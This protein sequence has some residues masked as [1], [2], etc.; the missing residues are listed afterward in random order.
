M[1]GGVTVFSVA[2]AVSVPADT[3]VM[4]AEKLA[5][6]VLISSRDKVEIAATGELFGPASVP[7]KSKAGSE[8]ESGFG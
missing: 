3:D 2:T 1:G 5:I 6:A 8:A 7:I 4:D